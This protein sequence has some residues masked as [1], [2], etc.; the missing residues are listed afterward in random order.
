MPDTVVRLVADLC[1]TGPEESVSLLRK[2]LV[3]PPA[4]RSDY[5]LNPGMR[6]GAAPAESLT[7]AAVLVPIVGHPGAPTVLLTKRTDH[8]RDHAGQVSFPGG[9]VEVGDDGPDDTALRE[10][11]EEVGIDRAHI[12]VVGRLA[13]YETRTGFNVTPVVGYVRPGFEL[14][15]DQFEVA[16]AFEVPLAFLLDPRNHERQSRQWQG[17]ERHFYAINYAEHFIWGATAGMLVNLYHRMIH[18]IG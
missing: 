11:A 5:D 17:V 10:T 6:E 2:H 14:K 18:R 4:Y 9:R 15:L 7:P 8:L 1:T 13:N 12:E 16:A 3:H